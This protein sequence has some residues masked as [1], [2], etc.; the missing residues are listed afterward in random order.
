M[1]NP[2][3]FNSRTEHEESKN[4]KV[5]EKVKFAMISNAQANTKQCFI[6]SN[7]NTRKCLIHDIEEF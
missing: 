6:A 1:S 2:S 3:A 5:Y 7:L 4:K